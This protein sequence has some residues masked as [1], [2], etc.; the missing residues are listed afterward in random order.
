[1]GVLA[2][3]ARIG[4][5]GPRAMQIA[6]V[7]LFPRKQGFAP[8]D[9]ATGTSGAGMLA[10]SSLAG[11]RGRSAAVVATVLLRQLKR[12]RRAAP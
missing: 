11:Q 4:A 2:G 12:Q 6:R 7:C 5:A 10:A 3:A 8:T 1:M 9:R